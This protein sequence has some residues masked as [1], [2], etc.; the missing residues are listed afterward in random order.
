MDCFY[1]IL[2]ICMM[3]QAINVC[4]DRH[5]ISLQMAINDTFHIPLDT[6][7]EFYGWNPGFAV[8]TSFS[9]YGNACL[10]RFIFLSVVA[11]SCKNERFTFLVKLLL[12]CL[13]RYLGPHAR[14]YKLLFCRFLR[15]NFVIHWKQQEECFFVTNS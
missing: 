13:K 15:W 8:S 14:S 9:F 6:N 2:R 7:E 3:F 4:S 10:S 11:I 1:V 12:L 5:S